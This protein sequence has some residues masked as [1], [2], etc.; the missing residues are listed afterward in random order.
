MG[1]KSKAF[2]H[3]VHTHWF[4]VQNTAGRVFLDW[5]IMAPVSVRCFPLRPRSAWPLC[6]SAAPCQG[7][8]RCHWPPAWPQSPSHSGCI[9]H[10]ALR[11]R[12]L[13]FCL[14]VQRGEVPGSKQ[15]GRSS[16]GIFATEFQREKMFSTVVNQKLSPTEQKKGS[17]RW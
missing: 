4:Q 16:P 14:H 7:H 3:Q 11:F 15:N 5:P 17:Q 6:F 12:T 10:C 8:K 1:F 2:G 13:C 9:G